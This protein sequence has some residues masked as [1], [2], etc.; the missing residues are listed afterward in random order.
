MT[1]QL[2][3]QVIKGLYRYRNRLVWVGMAVLS[4]VA[5]AG[6]SA[7]STKPA[8]SAERQ[9]LLGVPMGVPSEAVSPVATAEE[10]TSFQSLCQ[11][12]ATKRLVQLAR[13]NCERFVAQPAL[14]GQA[15]AALA[16]L[17]AESPAQDLDRAAEHAR[18][19][20]RLGNERGEFIL[21]L[22][23]LSGHAQPWNPEQVRDLLANADR[24]G[25]KPASQYL[26]RLAAQD[27]C[28]LQASLKPL[29]VPLFCGYRA[30]VLQQLQAHGMKHRLYG[31]DDWRDELS[32]GDAIGA[33]AVEL[34]FDVD[35]G[36]HLPRLARMR[37][38][39]DAGPQGLLRWDE[40]FDSLSHRYGPTRSV[41]R[42]H[43]AVWP[44]PD[45]TLVRLSR[46]GDRCLVA[47]E[48]PERLKQRD[49]HLARLRDGLRQARLLAEAHA[50]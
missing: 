45:G 2:G 5:V 1:A 47:Y 50:L 14:A 16:A 31:E 19:A 10:Q 7:W 30:E 33:Q 38:A 39:F 8:R 49:E 32:A 34:L 43:Q 22:L 41:Q 35:P 11:G 36:D 12:P 28:A 42:G 29:G 15:H 44:M 13:K 24:R 25:V 37:Y 20:V 9:P 6:W 21:A 23:M 3:K 4:G 40:L 26:Q 18:Q 17:L 46:K 48:H 27:E